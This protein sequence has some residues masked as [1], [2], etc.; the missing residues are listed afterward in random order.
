MTHPRYTPLVQS[1]PASVPFIGPEEL[2]RERGAAFTARLG[3]NENLFGPS[4]HAVRAMQEAAREVW[5]YPD[6]T[7]HDLRCTLARLLECGARNIVV[8]EGI[9]GLLGN[10]VRLL[11]A[12]GDTVVTSDGAYPTFNYHVAGFG[13]ALHKV[14][15]KDD[16]EDLD[17]L[18]DRARQIG[19]KLI[20]L[21]N[22][23]NPMGTWLPGKRI[24]QALDH[25]PRGCLLCLDEAYIEFAPCEAQA[26]IAPDDPRVIRMRTF[27]KAYGMA[28][29]RIGYALGAAPLIA[30][31]DRIRNHFGVNRIAQAGA[32]A[33]LHDT[34]WLDETRAKVDRA[35]TEIIRITRE[36]G[37][38]ALPSAANFVAVDCG[39]DGAFAR[40]VLEGLLERGVFVRMPFVAPQDRCIRIS[41][42]R[43]SDLAT[44]AGALP[45]ALADARR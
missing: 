26:P 21:A 18:I 29:A 37:L 12:P 20:Y 31:F 34:A 30:S 45:D 8:G 39:S 35:R 25:L 38:I 28:G 15:Y 9:D 14:P 23:D 19:A 3:A 10:L 13:G 40:R 11:V 4:P 6:A 43:A 24:A 44:L 16:H 33:A 22:P 5:M 17:A 36:N 1:L 41:C 7:S 27:S 32:V 2:E 42:G